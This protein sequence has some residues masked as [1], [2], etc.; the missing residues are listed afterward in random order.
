VPCS[1]WVVEIFPA[2]LR[3]LRQDISIAVTGPLQKFVVQVDLERDCIWVTGHAL[4]GFYCF[5]L[6][7]S[8]EGLFLIL[9]RAPK[10]GLVIQGK[11]LLR[12]ERLLLA[13]GGKSCPSKTYERVSFGSNKKQDWD[14][15]SRRGEP[16]EMMPLLFLAG[17]KVPSS[18]VVNIPDMLLF[19]R[20]GILVPNLIDLQHLGI[21]SEDKIDFDSMAIL[22]SCYRTIRDK[23]FCE[24]EER[25]YILPEIKEIPV[26]RA[27]LR[28]SFGSVFLQWS[29]GILRKMVIEPLSNFEKKI[30]FPKEA[31]SF[32]MLNKRRFNGDVISCKEHG[33]ILFDRFQK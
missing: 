21:F 23:L 27:H 22:Y 25:M 26:G 7:A 14:L 16:C 4:E 11:R 33:A 13:R 18:N 19:F 15:V 17:Q 28:A 20:S 1:D 6:K 29:Q 5:S 31:A 2:L 12:K 30:V 32:R 10:E 24:E 9:H 8:D 3:T